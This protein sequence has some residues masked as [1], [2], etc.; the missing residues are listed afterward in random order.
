VVAQE[1]LTVL[2][3]NVYNHHAGDSAFSG[4]TNA[5]IE[6]ITRVQPDVVCIQEA[7]STGFLRLL[8]AHLTQQ[9][10]RYMRVACT[11]MLRPDGWSE[12]IGIIHPGTG[13]AATVHHAPTGERIGI[14]IHLANANLALASVH[15]NPHHAETRHQQ[16]ARL[17]GEL[18]GDCPTLLCGDL[19]AVPGGGTLGVLSAR[20]QPL[21]P[22][23]SIK[24]TF[25][26][27]LRADLAG[28]PGVVLDHILGRA[29]EVDSWGVAGNESIGGVWPSD[30]LAVWA[31]VR[32]EAG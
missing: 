7:P 11:E 26:T 25:P 28:N 2:T 13:R 17:G 22:D 6:V 23:S 3:Y 29:V 24:A 8:A 20:F 16:A 32:P 1:S 31:R 14:S 5:L 12:H 18:P 30:H 19:N 15:L 4:R 10:R 21:A 9:Q 27:P